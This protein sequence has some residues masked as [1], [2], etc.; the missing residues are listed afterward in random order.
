MMT[1]SYTTSE[2][3]TIVHA[4]KIACKV[5]T[6][7]KRFQRFYGRPADSWI[8]DYEAELVELLKYDVVATVAYGFQR[9]G[10]W[11]EAAVRYKALPGGGLVPDDDPGKIRPNLDVSGASFTS[12]LTYNSRWAG[13]SGNERAAIA[14]ACPFRRSSGDEPGLEAGYWEVDRT[15]TAGGRGLARSSVRRW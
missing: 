4:R 10:K 5:A 12:F 3:F 8:D 6:D 9:N 14:A 7:L 1:V 2:T 15:Y 13:L 11:T